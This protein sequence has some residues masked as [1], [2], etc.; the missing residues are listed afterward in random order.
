MSYSAWSSSSASSK[1]E[2]EMVKVEPFVRKFHHEPWVPTFLPACW[3]SLSS[4][5]R[6]NPFFEPPRSRPPPSLR[7]TFYWEIVYNASLVN[8]EYSLS[9]LSSPESNMGMLLGGAGTDKMV[10]VP[11]FRVPS[12]MKLF[13]R[14]GVS[15]YL[16]I[17]FWQVANGS[18]H[19]L[20]KYVCTYF[21][22]YTK[23]LLLWK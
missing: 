20:I 16:L 11:A 5:S 4:C 14:E 21:L 22:L 7:L 3:C 18:S 12:L 15:G 17:H 23:Q 8:N 19:L 2:K 13:F 10:W 9:D 1:K 6:K